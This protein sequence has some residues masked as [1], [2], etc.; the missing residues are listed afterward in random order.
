M[1]R[2]SNKFKLANTIMEHQG[3]IDDNNDQDHNWREELLRN[4]T[5][6]EPEPAL[7]PVCETP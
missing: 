6:D 3:N 4:I 5:Q 1:K 7:A 2:H